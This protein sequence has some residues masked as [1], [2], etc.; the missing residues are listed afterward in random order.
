MP[1]DSHPNDSF[2]L[3]LEPGQEENQWPPDANVITHKLRGVE[4]ASQEAPALALITKAM[5]GNLQA[6]REMKGQKEYSSDEALHLFE[7]ER[8]A[9]TAR[10]TAKALERKKNVL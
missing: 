8:V 7:L 2:L 3:Q 6:E 5:R 9:R 1:T 10:R 4:R